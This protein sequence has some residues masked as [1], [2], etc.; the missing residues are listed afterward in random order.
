MIII[1]LD[2]EQLASIIK[3]SVRN[4]LEEK[5]LAGQTQANE[6]LTIKEA[7]NFLSLAPQTLYGFTS[8]RTIPFIKRGKKLYFQ[9]SDL[10]KWLAEGRKLTKS[11]LGATLTKSLAN[12]S[13]VISISRSINKNKKR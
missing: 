6:F 7:S 5:T 9:K 3:S 12:E 10:D 2:C 11:E 8:N 4:V 1:Q 13:E